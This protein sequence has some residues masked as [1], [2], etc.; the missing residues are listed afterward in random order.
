MANSLK[1]LTSIL[2]LLFLTPIIIATIQTPLSSK[3]I[4]ENKKEDTPV[5]YA[6]QLESKPDITEII[7]PKK[8]FVYFTHAHEA[9]RPILA[10]KGE[11]IAIY[12]PITNISTFQEQIAAQFAFHQVDTQFLE[13]HNPDV[14]D[15]YYTIRPFVQNAIAHSDYD[16]VLDI[17]RDAQKAK[18]TTLQIG[19]ETYAK[20][21]FVI[22]G[23]HANYKW[24]EQLAQN[25]SDQL[26]KLVPGIS[27]GIIVKTGK[28]VDGVYNQDLAKN[29][30]VVELGGVDNTEQ[31]VDRSIAILA[32]AISNMFNQQ[33]PS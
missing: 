29:L 21:I 8:A 7:E 10:D 22:G 30:L 24:N 18:V 26:N 9:Y 31:E 17:H 1:N 32:K 15:N 6:A 16:I 33:I 19:E 4:V 28:G 12:D 2:L 27:R 25:L 5:V 3:Q 13:D 11:K 14:M 23:E 20:F